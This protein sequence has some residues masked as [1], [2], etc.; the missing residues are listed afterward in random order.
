MTTSMNGKNPHAGIFVAL[1]VVF[2]SMTAVEY[3]QINS[4]K[5]T[6]SAIT[7]CIYTTMPAALECPK[8]FNQT[9]AISV[10]YEV[11]GG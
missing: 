3:A 9:Y 6:A 8:F 5:G 10:S 11:P 2:A 1:T 4:L 7:T